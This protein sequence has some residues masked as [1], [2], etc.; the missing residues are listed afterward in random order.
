MSGRGWG[1]LLCNLKT[2]CT[3]VLQAVVACVHV[4]C[5]TCKAKPGHAACSSSSTLFLPPPVPRSHTRH[6]RH[7]HTWQEGAADTEAAP[8][9]CTGL[10]CC[11]ALAECCCVC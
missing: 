1:R 4:L 9:V 2:I 5:Q 6:T 7:T 10:P 3:K 8:C 11:Q